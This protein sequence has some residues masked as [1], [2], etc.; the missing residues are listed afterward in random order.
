MTPGVANPIRL[1]AT[2][3]SY[4]KPPPAL[5]EGTDEVL[6]SLLGIASDEIDKLK[7]SG[8]IG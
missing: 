3:V 2:P 8:A 6:R 5:G 7:A 1:S 4:D